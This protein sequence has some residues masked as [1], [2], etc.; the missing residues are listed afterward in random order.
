[1][2]TNPLKKLRQSTWLSATPDTIAVPAI[3]SRSA[4]SVAIER[5][6][7]DDIAFALIP[8]NKERS[9]LTQAT[10][11]LEEIISMARKQ[12]AAGSDIAVTAAVREL[13]ARK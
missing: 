7:I 1:M 11:A 12:G 8:L 6:S 9:T 4:R 13:E 2:F 10:M 3:G 5:A